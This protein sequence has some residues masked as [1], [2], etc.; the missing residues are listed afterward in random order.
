MNVDKD[1]MRLAVN[2]LL[3]TD[4]PQGTGSLR[5]GESRCCLGILCEVA[6][7]NGLKLQVV[8]PID[9]RGDWLYGAAGNVGS[10]PIE[11]QEWY[12]IYGS[13]PML[14]TL[15]PTRYHGSMITN[16]LAHRANDELKLPFP[17]TGAMFAKT[18]LEETSPTC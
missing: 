10:L 12:G 4:K 11:V 2:E 6:V 18:F 14:E 1:R 17:V 7:A 5:H 9:A 15:E 13:S 16:I 3:T 8:P